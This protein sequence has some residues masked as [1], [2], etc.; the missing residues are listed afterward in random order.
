MMMPAD[1]HAVMRSP[2]HLEALVLAA[3]IGAPIAATAHGFLW[4]VDE[5]QDWFYTDLPQ[6][7]GFDRQPTWWPLPLWRSPACWSG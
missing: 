2:G 3:V 4:L 7:L 6:D 1:A 5:L